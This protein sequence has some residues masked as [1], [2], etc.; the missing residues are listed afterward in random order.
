MITPPPIRRFIPEHGRQRCPWCQNLLAYTPVTR[1]VGTVRVREHRCPVLGCGQ[2]WKTHELIA[3]MLTV[4]TP[5]YD[6][7]ESVRPA[8]LP[9]KPVV[10]QRKKARR[11]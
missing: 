3:P 7:D 2:R 6:D 11:Q 5:A 10:A 8:M 9:A 1:I 4:T